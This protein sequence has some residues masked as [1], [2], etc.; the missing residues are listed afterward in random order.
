MDVL[1][2]DANVLFS[3]A[4]AAEAGLLELWRLAE[5]RL[6]S[7]QYAI[8][9][10]SRNLSDRRQQSRL[11]RLLRRVQV[12]ANEPEGVLPHG[13]VLAAKDRPILAA[14]IAAGATHL[15]TGDRTH[16]GQYFGR[17]VGGVTILPPGEY[18]RQRR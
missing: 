2:L 6:V 14:A 1:F 13:L 7:S 9:E 5:V 17:S 12:R 16:F 3:A 18:L 8:E 15:L 10:A 4:Y 11:N